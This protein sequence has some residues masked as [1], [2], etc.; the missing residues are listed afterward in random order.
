MR[1]SITKPFFDLLTK[2][3]KRVQKANDAKN[4]TN[5]KIAT[6]ASQLGLACLGH[7]E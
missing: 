5:G 4:A 3:E 2:Q 6:S 7:L 1:I